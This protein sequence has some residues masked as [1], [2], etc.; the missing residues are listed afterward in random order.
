MCV[1]SCNAKDTARS[2]AI[3]L[4]VFLMQH[5]HSA[6]LFSCSIQPSC[7]PIGTTAWTQRSLVCLQSLSVQQ[8]W[9]ACPSSSAPSAPGSLGTWDA[10]AGLFIKTHELTTWQVPAATGLYRSS[11]QLSL[12]VSVFSTSLTP[13]PSF[14]YFPVKAYIAC[15]ALTILPRMVILVILFIFCSPF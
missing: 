1:H 7:P 5:G 6:S 11:M 8:L 2:D 12:Y 14:S 10:A 15:S 3:K 4:C 13:T 9:Q